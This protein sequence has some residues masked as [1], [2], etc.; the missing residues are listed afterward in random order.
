M[1]EDGV[2]AACVDED[3]INRW[4]YSETDWLYH[5]EKVMVFAVVHAQDTLILDKY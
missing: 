5:W 4:L 2:N 3:G 1:M